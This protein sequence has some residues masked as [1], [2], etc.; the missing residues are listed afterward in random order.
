MNYSDVAKIILAYYKDKVQADMLNKLQSE[1]Q[2]FLEADA[3]SRRQ[4]KRGLILN[5]VDLKISLEKFKSTYSIIKQKSGPIPALEQKIR[6]TEFQIREYSY[7]KNKS[8][9]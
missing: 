1:Y 6:Q 2:K 4:K 8:S 5:M 3:E 9:F 7:Q